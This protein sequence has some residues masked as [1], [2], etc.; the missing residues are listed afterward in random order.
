MQ[1][2]LELP[3]D[4]AQ[5]LERQ[6]KNLPRAVLESFA[7]EGYRRTPFQLGRNAASAAASSLPLA[8]TTLEFRPI[9][10]E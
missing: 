2:I 4:V 1:I 10:K 9:Q 6:V 7:L 8:E 5:G 3:G